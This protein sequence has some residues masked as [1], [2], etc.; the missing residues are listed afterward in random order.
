MD[1]ANYGLCEACGLE[2][3]EQRL[4]AMPFTRHCRDCQQD[5]EREAKTRYRRGDIE[6][7]PIEFGSNLAEDEIK[8]TT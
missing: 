2:I 5:R 1:E 4:K 3:A 7:E 8:S 6:Q